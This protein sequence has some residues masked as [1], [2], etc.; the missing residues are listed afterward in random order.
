MGAGCSAEETG[1][2]ARSAAAPSVVG[3]GEVAGAL[4][5]GGASPSPA[6]GAF[7][8]GGDVGPEDGST[9]G[10][11]AAEA[12]AGA[13]CCA[14]ASCGMASERTTPMTEILL[15][16]NDHQSTRRATDPSRTPRA[17]GGMSPGAC[18][19]FY[20]SAAYGV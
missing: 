3:G 10:W 12:G 15:L 18:R 19:K 1:T 13:L 7:S 8:S 9:E 16:M 20:T 17:F 6:A 14:R 2:G 5:V 4:S 11:G